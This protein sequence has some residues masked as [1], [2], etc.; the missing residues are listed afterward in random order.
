MQGPLESISALGGERPEP[1][2]QPVTKL[3]SEETV[4]PKLGPKEGL[5]SQ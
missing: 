1:R 3:S 5:P 2:G 4:L